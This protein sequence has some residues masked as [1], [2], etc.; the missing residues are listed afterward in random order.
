VT[1]VE[2]IALAVM[3][4][5]MFVGL[6]AAAFLVGQRPSF[7]VGAIIAVFARAL[8]T[9]KAYL[10]RRMKPEQESEL[11]QATRR[12]QEWD[13]LRKRPRDR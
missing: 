8:P 6:T 5:A 12:A 13:H 1:S 10:F 9:I 2:V 11:H 7:W 4:S 3:L